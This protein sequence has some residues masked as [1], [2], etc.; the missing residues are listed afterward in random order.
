MERLRKANDLT[1]TAI[2]YH[3]IQ[4]GN[5]RTFHNSSPFFRL[6]KDV[7]QFRTIDERREHLTRTGDRITKNNARSIVHQIEFF[8]ITCTRKHRPIKIY[9][10]I[11][12]LIERDRILTLFFRDISHR[13]IDRRIA[14]IEL[15]QK[16]RTLIIRMGFFYLFD[17]VQTVIHTACDRSVLLD[18]LLHT[19]ANLLRHLTCKSHILYLNFTEQPFTERMFYLHT[20]A[21]QLADCHNKN[22][23]QRA[24]I[25]FHTKRRIDRE[26]R[27]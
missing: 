2:F 21:K 24:A 6:G 17:H 1:V 18:D 15:T 23:C 7:C 20:T 11:L 4:I 5:V 22:E 19:L 27:H 9:M 12:A 8:Q 25:C 14:L 10:M 16:T 3:T 13:R 26:K